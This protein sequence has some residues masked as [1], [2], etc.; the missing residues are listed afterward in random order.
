MKTKA[1]SINQIVEEQVNRWRL[2]KTAEKPEASVPPVITI[3]REPGSGGRI[4][5]QK[6]A[7]AVGFDLFHQEV[8]HQMAQSARVSRLLVE[9][10]DERGLTIL[11]DWV[12]SLVEDHH[13]WPDEY[14]QH[15]MKVI[16]TI[17]EHGAAVIVGRGA[18]FVL[19]PEQRFSVRIVAPQKTRIENVAREFSV[20]P[21]E[22]KRR[23]I[24]TE[25]DRKAFVRKYYNADIS[26]PLNY[27]LVLNTGTL[28]IEEAADA[29][30]SLVKG[31]LD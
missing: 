3:S 18:N 10:L 5:A 9:T 25:S 7:A 19:P 26:D 1:R 23:V 30:C 28:R 6:V 13:L 15:L 4:V 31:R 27:D 16:G 17:G 2:L 12:A 29:I 11:E 24:R 22:A 21:K 8:I 20:S 14:L